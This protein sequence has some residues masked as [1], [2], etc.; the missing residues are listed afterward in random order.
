MK[1]SIKKLVMA[2][3]W[4]TISLIYSFLQILSF[5]LQCKGNCIESVSFLGDA[6]YVEMLILI[7]F[8][9][10]GLISTGLLIYSKN[11]V[12]IFNTPVTHGNLWPVLF[13]ILISIT[14]AYL[15]ILLLS[16][17]LK[18]FRGKK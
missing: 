9:L 15:I 16:K 4:G 14:T 18:K 3:L 1:F 17:L 12:P 8:G 2:S 5:S 13:G 11:Y 7:T 10:P 6:T